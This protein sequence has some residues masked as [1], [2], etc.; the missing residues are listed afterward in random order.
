MNTQQINKALKSVALFGG[1]YACNQIPKPPRIPT[2]FII[3]TDP[4]GQRGSHWVALHIS[5]AGCEYFDSF[6]FPPLAPDIQDYIDRYCG[7][8]VYNS[9]TLQHPSSES[10]GQYAIAF[11]RSKA[12]GHSYGDFITKFSRN[13]I[14]NENL[15]KR[16]DRIS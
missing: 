5:E 8:F 6:G 12:N 2:S 4:S 13:L 10:C 11:V 3:N 7:A 15:I 16:P 14:N 9:A 1:T